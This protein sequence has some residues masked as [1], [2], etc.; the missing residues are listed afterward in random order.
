MA[1]D[2]MYVEGPSLLKLASLNGDVI[3]LKCNSA[4]NHNQE[5]VE[6]NS[7]GK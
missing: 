4:F 5:I 3:D 2:A 1:Y 7:P 6:T